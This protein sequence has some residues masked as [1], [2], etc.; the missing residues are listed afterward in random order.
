MK[1]Q[2]WN[3]GVCALALVS[4]TALLSA[5]GPG[6]Q[7]GGDVAQ[8]RQA[9]FRGDYQG[10]LGYFQSAAQTDPNYIY[11][12]ELRTGILSYVGRAQYLNGQLAPARQ[13]LEKALSQHKSDNVAR[14]YLGLAI[15]RQ[16]DR[17][18]G[19]KDIG[20]GM[21]GIYDFLNYLSTTF[22]MSFGQFWDPNQAIRKAIQSDL[23]MISK[24]NF[25]LQTLIADGESI[26]M[27]IEQEPDN[28]RQQ[29]EQQ[30]E[31]QRRP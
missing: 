5:C 23:A 19:V 31:M 8:G 17:P 7:A 2:K 10:A 28:A 15:A 29:E 4:L 12:T 13:T 18:A 9:M 25:D 6:F 1:I 16:G 22:A 20:G 14:L 27:K 3:R 11:G 21:K 26:G 30:M 24:G